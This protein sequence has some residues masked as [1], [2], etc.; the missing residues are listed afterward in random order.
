MNHK[1][2][3]QAL[4]KRLTP[5]R[6]IRKIADNL[7]IFVLWIKV[8]E[9]NRAAI[10]ARVKE[11][12][13]GIRLHFSWPDQITNFAFRFSCPQPL[14]ADLV[15]IQF[16]GLFMHFYSL[17]VRLVDGLPDSFAAF[18]GNAPISDGH[19]KFHA[20]LSC[21]VS[22]GLVK[23]LSKMLAYLNKSRLLVVTQ[24]LADDLWLVVQSCDWITQHHGSIQ[25]N[26]IR[27][28]ALSG[29]VKVLHVRLQCREMLRMGAELPKIR[30]TLLMR[31]AGRV[32]HWNR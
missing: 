5:S 20:E 7:S 17:S 19:F 3:E 30:N 27:Q 16:G 26:L 6:N 24:K 14:L 4:T 9:S 32:S 29:D 31:E 13:S 8:S 10:F 22:V 2:V 28:I 18:S 23:K 15:H 12:S 11:S 21:E 1:R 25:I